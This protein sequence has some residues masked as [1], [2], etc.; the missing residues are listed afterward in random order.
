M[1][2]C[3]PLIKSHFDRIDEEVKRCYKRAN[4][5]RKKGHDPEDKVDIPLAKNMAE[6]VE[7]LISVVAPQLVGTKMT[8]RIT[9]LEAKHGKLDWRV[10][11]LI[12]EEVAKETFCTFENR[13]QS[14]EVGIRVGFAYL[15][16][17]IVAA[18]LEGFIELKLKKRHDGKEY[19]S[20]CYAGPVRGA[21]GT[22]AATSVILAD[23]IRIKMGYS[24][25][26]PT[27][28]EINRI[29][30][31]VDDYHDR[32]TNLQYKPSEHELRFLLSK[33]PVEISGDPTETLEVS[34]FK[35]LPRVETNRLRSGVCL[36]LCEGLAQ[37]AAKL[38]KRLKGWGKDFS[39]DWEFLHEFL[40]IQKAEKAGGSTE[41]AGK[42]SPN[43]TF[44]KDLVAGRPI[45]THPMEPGGFRLRYGRSRTTGFSAAGI[46]PA[47]MHLLNR[48]VA[49]GTQLKV[50]R[51]GKAAAITPVDTIEGPIVKT[52]DGSV[53]KITNEQEAKRLTSQTQEIL[54]LGDILFNYGDFSENG[55]RLVPP[56]YS[57]EWW[58]QEVERE[59]VNIFGTL[60]AERLA[61]LAGIPAS[62]ILPLFRRPAASL[63]AAD[64][65][66]LARKIN[67]PLHPDHDFYWYSIEK[68]GL[69]QLLDWFSKGT[70][71]YE[72]N[73]L[74]KFV[75]PIDNIPKRFL[76]LIGCPHLVVAQ[77][78]VVI[79]R[80]EA[81]ILDAL[82][83]LG[84][85]PKLA[86]TI[87]GI[88]DSTETDLL[89]LLTKSSGI[90]LRDKSGT[91]IGAR[92][93]RPEKAKMRQLTGSPHVLFPV[94]SE[95]GRLRS[96]QAALG[97]KKVT[98][99]FP[100]LRCDKCGITLYRACEQCGKRTH[101]QYF[102]ERTGVL[103]TDK[104]HGVPY[105]MK[106]ID[107]TRYFESALDLLKMTSYPDLIKGVRGTSNKDHIPEHLAKGILRA[108]HQVCVNKDGTTRY[109]MSELPITHFKPRE[110]Q[111]TAEG[112]LKLGY[113]HDCYGK[114]L[115][116]D[117]QLVEI[118]PQDVILPSGKEL[119]DESADA[120][121]FR[122]ALF[123][124]DEL[125]RLYGLKP[126][127]SL[128]E[129]HELIGHLVIGLAPHISAGMIGRIIGFSATQ[130]CYAHPLWHAALRRDCDGDE[131]C[132]MMLMDALLNF[133]R[134]YLPD[135]RGG[136]T[137]DS[138]LVLTSQLNPAEV[139]DMVHGLDIV[140]NYSL[141]FY[142]SA[143]EGKYPWEVDVEQLKSFIGT[144][145]QYEKMGFTHNVSDMNMGVTCSAYKI[146]PSM[147]EK[148]RG[149]MDLADRIRAVDA[150]DVA[151]LVIEKHFIRDTKGNLRKFSMQQFRCVACNEKFRRP[152][153][154]GH[155]TKCKGKLIF[156]ISEGSVTKYL[157]PSI[158]LAEKYEL[159]LYLKQTL[160]LVK[161]RIEDVFG[162]EHD[163]QEGL[164]KWFG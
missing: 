96:F 111:Q 50:E 22:A 45:L 32:I 41:N 64:A 80:E 14:M 53:L 126:Y 29:L 10:G 83:F 35:D 87:K 85:K 70:P 57:P 94:G 30:R 42:L 23:Y 66:S 154:L 84:D 117:D 105:A 107:I 129:K 150:P 139:D 61:E 31:E 40:K 60:D 153:L 128:K 47:T 119:I 19:F 13:L 100:Q 33:L 69:I 110:I 162:R 144:E 133:S 120:V 156:T 62:T 72:H 77:D 125:K 59:S 76:E 109:D 97:V 122:V 37:K 147:Q 93:G 108:Y 17:G 28:D 146:L 102:D 152:P 92:M 132:V 1:A 161:R 159:P 91:F 148:L 21:G 86:K 3:S 15:T 46:H 115:I 106:G 142:E 6:R 44:I 112:V 131:C 141:T 143:R 98:S 160:E 79:Q 73:L 11:F 67:V 135:K 123:V 12:A 74:A 130:G 157:G 18:P 113:T 137:M 95:G 158:S 51:P 52:T 43:Y 81:Q 82:C 55:H 8:K 4:D 65:I 145:R 163:R 36:V 103:S 104:G 78:Q 124:D 75:L 114:E 2:E 7:G 89:L 99:A 164:G 101:P 121:L 54:F 38:W 138:P 39:L 20:V 151:R 149:Q 90:T 116:S 27:E 5:A 118:F 16:G 71:H 88:I 48:Y 136:R 63:K 134:Q 34:N 58:I 9:E 26:D 49:T 155:C 25:Y 24:P 140:W 56:G 68:E 127:Y